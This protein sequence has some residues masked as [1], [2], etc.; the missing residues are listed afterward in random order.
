MA[1]EHWKTLKVELEEDI[2]VVAFD[3]PQALN[4][5]TLEMVDEL[6]R[7]FAAIEKDDAVRGVILTGSGEKA[8]MAGAD[9][10]AFADMDPRALRDFA[11]YGQEHICCYIEN[12]PKPV[13]AAV[14]GYA[15]G[16]GCELAMTCDIR[17]ASTRAVFGQPEVSIGIMPLYA[18]T[19][20]L[21]R[22]VG[23]GRAKELIM[24]CRRVRAE[25]A[26]R[27]GLVS[28]VVEPEALLDTAK[29]ILR[30]I[31]RNAPKS[32]YFSKLAVN[33]AADLSIEEAGE[34][35]RDLAAILFGTADKREGIAAF[36][37]KRQPSY[38][39]R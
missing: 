9:V 14:N 33:Q 2:A 24:T 20:R 10:A 19:K 26:E 16:G 1:Y 8:F 32:V 11:A 35:E 15:L 28:R 36:L 23:F 37:E 38:T 13:V 4:T 30:Q 27:I 17:V 5:L 39:G 31:F 21:Q 34:V 18:A 3:R 7:A 12:F 25:E 6:R 29:D 22:L